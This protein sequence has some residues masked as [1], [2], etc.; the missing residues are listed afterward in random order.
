[1]N[2][3]DI[4]AH[5]DGINLSK[6]SCDFV[7]VKAT[8]GADYFNRCFNGHANKTLKL[9]RLLGMYHYANGG[10]VKKEADFF[11]DKIKKFVGKGIIALDWESDN[12]PRFGRD[13]A[14]WCEAW[15][16]YIY[17]KTGIKPFVYIQ[18]S[19]M[20]KVKSVGYPLWIAQYPDD[21]YT[22]FQKTPWNEGVYDCAIRQYS[23][24]GRLNGYSGNLDLNKSY[25]SKATWQKYAGVK[26]SASSIKKSTTTKKKSN[27]V[28]AKE[29]YDDKWGKG[30]DRKARLTKAGYDYNT[31]QKLVNELVKKYEAIAV[32]VLAGKWG[33]DPERTERLTAAG[34][35]AKKIQDIVNRLYAIE[36]S[37]Q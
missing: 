16:N 2:G 9:G 19:M 34:Y 28:I 23:S 29:V 22:G 21:E 6:V 17:R 8:E 10:D 37:K 15:C 27:E 12:N 11:L 18:K 35:D 7:I 33:N 36:L 32:E 5:Q 1:M 31:I 24:H 13:D 30:A 26:A 3:I 14:E 4:S 25:I 20:D